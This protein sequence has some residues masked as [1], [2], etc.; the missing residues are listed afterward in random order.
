METSVAGRAVACAIQRRLRGL[1]QF[2]AS[3]KL[4][5]SL[6]V[7][8]AAVLAVA[9]LLEAEH[10]MAYAHWYVYKSAWFSA[11]LGLL[12][13]NIFCAAAVR[14][15]WKRHQTGFV[16][17]HAGLLVL[18]AG[19][20]QSFLGGIEGQLSFVEGEVSDKLTLPERSQIT[21]VWEGRNDEPPY[22]FGFDGGPVDWQAGRAL[23]L[24]D[25]DGVSARILRFYRHARPVVRWTTD[26]PHGGPLVKIQ[27]KGPDG[28]VVAEPSLSDQQF[29]DALLMGPI[30]VQLQRAAYDTMLADFLDPALPDA[31]NDGLLLAYYREGVSRIP[32]KENV[33]NKVAIGET[34]AQVEIVEYLRNARPEGM[35]RF[36]NKGDQP[37]NPFVELR[38]YLPG[39]KEPLRQIAFAKDPLLN[40]DGVF[41]HDCPVKFRFYHPAADPTA[42][43]EFLQTRDGK[44]YGRVFHEGRVKPHGIVS[45]GNSFTLA[46]NF[47]V[48][49]VQYS[50]RARSE[51]AFEPAVAAKGGPSPEPAAL[52]EIAAGGAAQQV[53]LQRNDLHNGTRKLDTPLG[54]MILHYGHGQVPLEFSLKLED[55][56]RDVNPGRAGDAAFASVVRIIDERGGQDKTRRVTMNEPLTHRRFTFYQSGFNQG[57]HGKQASVLS[58]AYDPGRPLKYTGSL[59]ICLGIAVMFYMR[60]YFFKRARGRPISGTPVTADGLAAARMPQEQTHRR[61][62]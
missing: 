7:V 30:R 62:A 8:L 13:V 17:T 36:V 58:V 38:V 47:S 44:L 11:L 56:R 52:V 59:M 54:P 9:T 41:A 1:L 28:K 4:A 33:G 18:L 40:L 49:V 39:E 2:L 27:V 16:I 42:A 21:A 60:A 3:L 48:S 50:P 22:L 12:G 14:F 19:S 43:V 10:G 29:G 51:L 20:I 24:G 55:F 32:V 45:V 6:M 31:S 35:G 15:P 37:G 23:S 26:G 53:W 5:V 46:M 61:A 25:I 34:G 57:G